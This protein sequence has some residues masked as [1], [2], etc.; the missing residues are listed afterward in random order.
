[1][2]TPTL[3]AANNRRETNHRDMTPMA[4]KV[5]RQTDRDFSHLQQ[6]R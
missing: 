2:E 6:T 4:A 3:V 1:M 5:L